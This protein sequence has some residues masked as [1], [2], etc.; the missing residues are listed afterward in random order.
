MWRNPCQDRVA[1]LPRKSV[2]FYTF[3]LVTL[4][5]IGYLWYYE[6]EYCI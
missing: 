1:Y 5:K 3:P 6:Q 2:C 4:D